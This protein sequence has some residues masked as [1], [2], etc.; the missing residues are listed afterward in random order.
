M[1]EQPLESAIQ[2]PHDHDAKELETCMNSHTLTLIRVPLHAGG[3]DFEAEGGTYDVINPATEEPMGVAPIASLNDVQRAIDAANAAQPAWAA[4][5]VKER[6]RLLDALAD[7]LDAERKRLVP[8]LG[9]EMGGIERGP[10][11]S[12][13]TLDV[14]IEEFHAAAAD[15]MSDLYENFEPRMRGPEMI[16]GV[17]K[18]VPVGVVAI[19]CAYNAPL[20][21]LS[22]MG[23]PALMAGNT[24]IVKPAP[25]DP[26]TTLELVRLATEVGFPAGVINSVN[27]LTPEVGEELVRNPGVH[28]VGFTGSP[29]VGVQIAQSAAAQLK[30]VLLEL[31]GKGAFIIL[32]DADLDKAVPALARTWTFN[33]GQ[34]CAAPTRALVHHSVRDEVIAR[35]NRLAATLKVG[36]GTEPGVVVGPV[37]SEAQRD[38][39]ERYVQSARDEGATIEIGGVRPDITPGFY[40][41]PT[42]ITDARPDM[43]VVREE[44]FG[45]VI[46]MLT[47]DTDEEAVLLANDTVYGLTNYVYS[48]DVPRAYRIAEQLVSGN[49][50][51]NTFLGAGPGIGNMPFGGRK[52]SGYGRKGGRHTRQAFTTT[53]GI[54]LGLN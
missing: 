5:P 1:V 7:R 13:S 25:Q 34:I 39:I 18:R 54:T 22:T 53:L 31:G 38:R 41:A 45:P 19:I 26:L 50:N 48:R 33:S 11:S 47:F 46:S 2:V 6:A 4:L 3:E 27:G 24:I 15:P 9:M 43:T 28:A 40:V 49:V 20:V 42:L 36:P 51:V 17:A 30:P 10:G 14:A 32:E 23:A 37:I 52:M 29:Q 21:N 16:S 12:G 8:W 44:I 35:L